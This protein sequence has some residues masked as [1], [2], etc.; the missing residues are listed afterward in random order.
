M[1]VFSDMGDREMYS[2]MTPATAGRKAGPKVIRARELAPDVWL[3]GEPARGGESGRAAGLSSSGS[4]QA[5]I[6][7]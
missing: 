1:S 5:P 6:Q 2:P 3:V 7:G 4:S